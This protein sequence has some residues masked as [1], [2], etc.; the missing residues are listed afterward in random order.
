MAE[1]ACS[2]GKEDVSLGKYISLGVFRERDIAA[3]VGVVITAISNLEDIEYLDGIKVRT[4]VY[5]DD[6]SI[7]QKLMR[8]NW[9][10]AN[11]EVT[12]CRVTKFLQRFFSGY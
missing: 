8:D 11:D 1:L 12:R 2:L 3:P 7:F 5:Y 10:D 4:A 6:G 9:I